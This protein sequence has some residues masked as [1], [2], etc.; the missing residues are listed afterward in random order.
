MPE[1]AVPRRRV[2]IEDEKRDRQHRPP[3]GLRNWC[4]DAAVMGAQSLLAAEAAAALRGHEAIWAWDLV[5]ENSNCVIPP[6]RESAQAW[7]TRMSGAIRDADDRALVVVGLHME[8][9][10]ENCSLGSREAAHWCDFL[11]MHG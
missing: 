9:L 8:D 6:S 4:T 5:N 11:S 1:T 3:G 10:E 7:R 2:L